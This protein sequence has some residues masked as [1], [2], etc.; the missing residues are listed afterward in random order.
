[1]NSLDLCQ[2]P[3]ACLLG[4]VEDGLEDEPQAD[5]GLEDD[6]QADGGLEDVPQADGGHCAPG[7]A[8]QPGAPSTAS[9]PSRPGTRLLI[10]ENGR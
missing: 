1:M 6:H 4:H 2:C 3:A 10:L 8:P 9:W 5:G 7:P